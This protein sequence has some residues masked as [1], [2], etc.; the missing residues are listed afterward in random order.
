MISTTIKHVQNSLTI[1]LIIA[2]KIKMAIQY[3][4]RFI[5]RHKYRSNRKTT[6]DHVSIKKYQSI[7]IKL[8]HN[9]GHQRR[10]IR[11]SAI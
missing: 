11:V 7:A 4:Y 2:D 3:E 6:W 8:R 5:K 1:I 9:W 10:S